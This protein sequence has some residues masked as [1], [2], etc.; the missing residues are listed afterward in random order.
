MLRHV[1]TGEEE[2]VTLCRGAWCGEHFRP[3]SV[4]HQEWG[5]SFPSTFFDDPEECI[6]G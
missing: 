2:T 4:T 6:H 3:G 5:L 1:V